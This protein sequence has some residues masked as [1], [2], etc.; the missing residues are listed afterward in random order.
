MSGL[1]STWVSLLPFPFLLTSIW[2]TFDTEMSKREA[3][4][5][6]DQ[7]LSFSWLRIR[8]TFL[9][10]GRSN[11]AWHSRGWGKGTVLPN[12][13]RGGEGI[14]QSVTW[15]FSKFISHILV[16]LLVFGKLIQIYLKITCNTRWVRVRSN[17]TKWHMGERESKIGQKVSHIIWMAPKRIVT[18]C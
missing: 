7:S 8:L 15:H 5:W 10:K 16:C 2:C 12:A 11:N 18:F 4:S 9:A 3:W 14:C 6:K 13:T 1:I 17:N